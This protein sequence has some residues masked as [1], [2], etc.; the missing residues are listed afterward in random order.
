VGHLTD[1]DVCLL[2]QNLLLPALIDGTDKMREN[3]TL[4]VKYLTFLLCTQT[5][6]TASMLR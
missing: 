6:H 1:P 3:I 2:V 5:E 4:L